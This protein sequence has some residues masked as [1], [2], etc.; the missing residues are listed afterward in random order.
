MWYWYYSYANN[1]ACAT[2]ATATTITS[3]TTAA[4]NASADIAV[5]V[6]AICRYCYSANEFCYSEIATRK[7]KRN[8]GK[9]REKGGGRNA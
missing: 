2:T 5:G 6:A 4:A 8:K 7:G 9:R 3:A 1:G